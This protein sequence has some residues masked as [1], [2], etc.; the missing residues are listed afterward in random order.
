MSDNAEAFRDFWTC[1]AFGVVDF[2]NFQRPNDKIEDF[3]NSGE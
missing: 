3:R 1:K 2:N